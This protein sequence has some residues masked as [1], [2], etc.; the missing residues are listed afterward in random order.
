MKRKTL[1][2]VGAGVIAVST[3][4]LLSAAASLAAHTPL[5]TVRMEQAS[6]KMHFLPT[7]MNEV[8]YIAEEGY[9][10]TYHVTGDTCGI[11]SET[12]LPS[13]PNMTCATCDPVYTCVP[14]SCQD[15]C[16]TCYS[17]CLGYIT[18]DTSTCMPITCFNTFCDT[19]DETCEYT[20]G[21]TCPDTCERTCRY[22]CDKPCQP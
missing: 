8:A 5:Y 11:L 9:V 18:C 22:T 20:C 4:V 12:G 1:S 10:L 7:E 16:E 2:L 3:L 21:P 6:S 17:T 14:T 19:C 13:C 15:T